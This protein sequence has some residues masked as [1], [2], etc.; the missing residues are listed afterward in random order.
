M[1]FKTVWSK[2][3]VRWCVYLVLGALVLAFASKAYTYFLEQHDAENVAVIQGIHLTM[4]DAEGSNLPPIPDQNL[5]D[6]TLAGIDANQN[7]IRDDVEL[8]LFKMYPTSTPLRA[9]ALQYAQT[10]S[11]YFIYVKYYKSYKAITNKEDRD[12]GC[13]AEVTSDIF[14]RSQAYSTSIKISNM[15]FNTKQ[16]EGEYI[17][18]ENAYFSNPDK[19]KYEKVCDIQ[20]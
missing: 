9:A 3:L 14:G 11:S 15:I 18:I 4:R 12:W 17:E 13:I 5:S 10:L 6:S 2:S 19:V 1:S 7:N 16:R 8:A 20:S